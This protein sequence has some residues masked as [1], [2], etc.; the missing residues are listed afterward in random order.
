MKF[1]VTFGTVAPPHW[2]DVARTADRLG[3][4]SL[5]LPEHLVL[6]LTMTGSPFEGI[7]HPPLPAETPVYEPIAYLSYVAGLT[8]RV[9]LGTYVYLLGIRHPFASA[10]GWATLDI[11]SGGRA[12]AGVGAGWLAAEWEAVGLDPRSRGGRLDEAIGICRQLWTEP[13]IEHH[14]HHFDFGPVAFEPKPVQRPIPIHVGGES[15]VALERAG[16]L[17]DG[18]LGMAHTPESAASSAA[19]LRRAAIESGRPAGAVEVT[20][21]GS[22]DTAADLA[23]WEAAGVDRLIVRPWTRSSDAVEAMTRFAAAFPSQFPLPDPAAGT[24]SSLRSSPW[25]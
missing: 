11:V 5:W 4:E 9:R 24:P 1:G 13:S 25:R 2:L 19:R 6:P 3:Y 22:C 23:A 8:A 15:R 17:G 18:W 10:R 20:V 12:M 7:D 16:R 21:S 14:G